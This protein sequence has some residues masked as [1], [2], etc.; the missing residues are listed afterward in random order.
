METNDDDEAEEE[1]GSDNGSG[2]EDTGKE[3]KV[4]A[5]KGVVPDEQWWQKKW[6]AMRHKGSTRC[7]RFSDDGEGK[8]FL[9]PSISP[10]LDPIPDK[11]AGIV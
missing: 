8:P 9:T 5:G 3:P 4:L 6:S 2:G 7:V 1:G 10:Q 11:V